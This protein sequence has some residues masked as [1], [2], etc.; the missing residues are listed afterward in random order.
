MRELAAR[1]RWIDIERAGIWG[2]SG[3]GFATA[4]AM[5]RHP[6]FFKVGISESGNHDNRSY[7]DDW[8]E[9]FQG[10]LARSGQGDNY[11]SQANQLVAANLRGKLLLAHGG[12][13]DNV[14]PYNT[15]LVVDA[16]IKANKNFDLIILP[17]A[18]HGF[19]ADSNYMMRRRWDYFV[20]HLLGAEPPPEYQMGR[21]RS[22]P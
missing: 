7:E 16:L 1:H 9:R 4:A 11:D 15:Y 19:G 12:M 13:D 2:H 10:L 5:F 14:P 6:D 22:R 18:R 17:H 3:G 20:K 8:G 21:P